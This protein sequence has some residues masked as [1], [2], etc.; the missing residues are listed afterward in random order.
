M[1]AMQA[2]RH[3]CAGL[4]HWGMRSM[5]RK[6]LANLRLGAVS[7][8]VSAV[9]ASGCGVGDVELNGKVFDYLG[10]STASQSRGKDPKIASRSGLVIPPSAERL[11]EPGSAP[12]EDPQLASL[13]DPDR[14]LEVAKADLER[15]QREYCEVHYTQA[16][17]RGDESGALNAKGPLGSCAPSVFTSLQ[18]WQK[19]E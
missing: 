7:A 6:S 3:S 1:G 5:L 19:G 2:H 14:K 18:K 10:V 12:A 8:T 16:K 17:A 4:A 15:Q 11:P 9:L 13:D